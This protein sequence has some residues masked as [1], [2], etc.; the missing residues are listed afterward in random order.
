MTLHW[1]HVTASY[2]L[3]LGAFAALALASWNR[4]AA[5]KRL[6][7]QLDPRAGGR[8]QTPRAAGR[9]PLP[10]AA[11]RDQLPRAA[12]REQDTP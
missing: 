4:H 12:G 2:V 11:G 3:V 7:A 5:A 6:L 10:R 1:I 9:D 8:E